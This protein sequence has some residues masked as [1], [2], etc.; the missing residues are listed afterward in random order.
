MQMNKL[1][2]LRFYLRSFKWFRSLFNVSWHNVLLDADQQ[3]PAAPAKFYWLT[4]DEYFNKSNQIPFINSNFVYDYEP[5]GYLL[6]ECWCT[7]G[8]RLNA[9]GSFCY[10]DYVKST[11]QF[12]FK[13]K[14]SFCGNISY[15]N[16]DIIPGLMP[17]NELGIPYDVN[18]P[19]TLDMEEN[20]EDFNNIGN[21]ITN[22]K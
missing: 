10:E 9:S 16:P 3:W 1:N 2:T 15:Y 18:M 11:K 17:C 14:C 19:T 7:C 20:F 4:D 8:Q 6:T 13:Y 22:A 21:L 5:L 12:V